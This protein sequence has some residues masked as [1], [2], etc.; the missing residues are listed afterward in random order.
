MTTK[1]LANGETLPAAERLSRR[2]LLKGIAATSALAAPFVADD[3]KA[4]MET[5]VSSIVIDGRRV[6]VDT[7]AL[8][9]SWLVAYEDD[10]KGGA[11]RRLSD[12]ENDD[13]V[14]LTHDGKLTVT[15]LVRGFSLA[16]ETNRRLGWMAVQVEGYPAGTE[17][18]YR[19]H[20]IG[21]VV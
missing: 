10:R 19:V 20:V 5:S 14:V 8:P 13:Y 2:F 16:A 4:D 12:P 18:S 17:V 11:P 3:A 21:K 15:K 7:E 1:I 9:T 6:A